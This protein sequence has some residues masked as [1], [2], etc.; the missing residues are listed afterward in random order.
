M[1][2]ENKVPANDN[3][4]TWVGNNKKELF[5]LEPICAEVLRL[6]ATETIYGKYRPK[7]IY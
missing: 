2:V 5:V 3:K 1:W 4:W 7:Q 6:Q